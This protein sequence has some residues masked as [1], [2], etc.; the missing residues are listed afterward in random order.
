MTPSTP[1]IGHIYAL[2]SKLDDIFGEGVDEPPRAARAHERAGPR[3]GAGRTGSISS[4]RK[5][6]AR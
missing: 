1:S 6:T 4:R 5:A 2:Q 3:L